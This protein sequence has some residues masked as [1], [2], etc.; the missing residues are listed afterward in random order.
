M[1][2]AAWDGDATSGLVGTPTNPAIVRVGLVAWPVRGARVAEGVAAVVRRPFEWGKG[3]QG[4]LSAQG[5]ERAIVG[6]VVML[7]IM[8]LVQM[9]VTVLLDSGVSRRAWLEW[10]LAGCFA[11]SGILV[12]ASSAGDRR[13]RRSAVVLDAA[14]A[15]AVILA[16]PWFAP[17]G[18]AQPWTDWPIAVSFLVGAEA[19]A[20]LP[21]RF[22]VAAVAALMAAAT[23]WLVRGAPAATQAS[24]G[25]QLVPYV[26]FAVGCFLFVTYLRRLAGW[27]TPAPRRSGHWRVSA[28][29][30]CCI[31]R[32]GC[33]MTSPIC[34]APPSRDADTDG[35]LP[36]R[37]ARLAEALASAREIEAIV[38]GTEPASSNLA[39]DLLRLREQFTDLPLMMNVDDVGVDLPATVVYRI[40]EATRSALQNVRMHA[41]AGE[42]VVYATADRGSWL[43][44]VHDDG[45]GFDPWVRRG[46]GLG[47]L[48]VDA[49]ER[50][51]G[52]VRIQ[53]AP[54]Q[55]TLIEMTG[56][57]QWTIDST[58][59]GR[60]RRPPGDRVRAGARSARCAGGGGLPQRGRVPARRPLLRGGAAGPAADPCDQPHGSGAGDGHRGDPAHPDAGRGPVVV[61]TAIAEEMLLAACLAAGALGAVTKTAPGAPSPKSSASWPVDT[62]GSIRPSPGRSPATRS[63]GTPA[64]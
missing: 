57:Q 33:L 61:Y 63:A 10:L 48:I 23:S 30:G 22:A 42:V 45:C 8:N 58:A 49:V 44:S 54:G 47:E 18:S 35:D 25:D 51:G 19:S 15:A 11:A 64:R 21:P 3:P 1:V 2:T 28:P 27:P 13:L 20:C 38:R 36:Q 60:G 17:S 14:V 55:G 32:I 39:A 26:G 62:C 12:M 4:L 29:A 50:M 7:K 56:G 16:A 43:V 5:V 40:R 31:P 53:S 46:V 24:G 34:C 37:Q 6:A 52:R 9:V 59:G 41:H